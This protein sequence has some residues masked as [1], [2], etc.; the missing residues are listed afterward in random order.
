MQLNEDGSFL[1]YQRSNSATYVEYS[2]TYTLDEANAVISGVYSDGS[3]WANSYNYSINA[4]NEL[5]FVNTNNSAEITI[6]EPAT[7][8]SIST[9]N[10]SRAANIS[11]IKPL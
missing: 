1:L 8:P 2:G 3:S 9:L 10:I 6:Y 4:N 11:N 7:M 5:V